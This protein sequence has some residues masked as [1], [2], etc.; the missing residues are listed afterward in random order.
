V[1][2]SQEQLAEKNEALDQLN[3][4]L[5]KLEAKIKNDKDVRSLVTVQCRVLTPIAQVAEE[6]V[7]MFVEQTERMEQDAMDMREEAARMTAA[8]ESELRAAEQQF[9]ELE[10]RLSAERQAMQ[11]SVV[12]AVTMVTAHKEFVRGKLAEVEKVAREV[13]AKVTGR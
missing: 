8:Q 1:D 13:Q 9:R 7:K 5:K 10:A 12:E 3:N 4:K 2:R 6:E 11:A